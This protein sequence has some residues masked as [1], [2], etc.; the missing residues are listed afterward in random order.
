MKLYEALS[1]AL[2]AEGVEVVFGLIAGG[3]DDVIRDMA[4]VKRVRYVKV[5]HEEVAIGMADG[6]SRATGKIGVVLIDGGPGLANACAPLL[7]ARMSG[8]RLLVVLT[9]SA[10]DDRHIYGLVDRHKNMSYEQAPL[11]DATAGALQIVRGPETLTNDVQQ[12]F[13]H[14]NLGKGP[15]VLAFNGGRQEMPSG[16][17]YAPAP[18]PEPLLATPKA[19]DIKTLAD[20]IRAS[21]RPLIIAGR[22][23]W[24]SGARDAL[25]ELA[26]RA[27]ALTAVSLLGK[28]MYEGEPYHLGISGGFAMDEAR[29]VLKQ[30][31]LVIAFGCQWNDYTVGHG[32]LYEDAKVVQVDISP[33]AFGEYNRVDQAILGDARQTAQ[34]LLMSLDRIE[35][36]DWR[37]PAM[38]ARIKA[39]D[40]FKARDMSE[41]PG[42]ANVRRV[43][44]AIDRLAPKDRM[45]CIDIGLFM[46]PPAN[47]INVP[48]PDAQIFPWQLGRMGCGLPVA[49]GAALGRPD[50]LMIA[51]VGDGGMMAAMNTVNTLRTENIPLL[52]VVMDDDGYG[53]DRHIFEMQGV[54]TQVAD[55][56]SPDLVSIAQAFGLKAHRVSSGAQM[57]AVMRGAFRRNESTLVHVLMDYSIP[58]QEMD[59]AIYRSGQPH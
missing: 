46:G 47:Y 38:A 39:F 25:A 8:S 36:P 22:G 13:R 1:A 32:H 14:I 23:A 31:D 34:A 40:R 54:K 29:A 58:A 16:W 20:K 48:A 53:A 17:T 2:V 28:G 49:A 59:F 52:L 27:G 45:L 21:K 41:K 12:A 35:R 6:Y 37:G 30:A 19:A 9:G 3:I 50:R 18:R 26:D 4:D 55:L 11:I 42:R 15:I 10:N 51:V 7:A 44:D 56:K 5:R 33:A 24:R 43:V 57:E